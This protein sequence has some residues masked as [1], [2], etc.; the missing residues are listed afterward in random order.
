VRFPTSSS[1]LRRAQ[2]TPWR[3]RTLHIDPIFVG[4]HHRFVPVTIDAGHVHLFG[5]PQGMSTISG[6]VF[7]GRPGLA[8][9][10]HGRRDHR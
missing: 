1:P 2:W 7:P 3:W 5:R 6:G 4:A 8:Q 9:L 10:Q